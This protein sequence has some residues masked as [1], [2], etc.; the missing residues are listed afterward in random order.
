[1]YYRRI[2]LPAR[3][4]PRAVQPYTAFQRLHFA[5][6]PPIATRVVAA[7]VCDQS[8]SNCNRMGVRSL[9]LP[10]W[11]KTLLVAPDEYAVTKI[12]NSIVMVSRGGVERGRA[13]RACA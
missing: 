9:L 2:P 4:S 10:L 1:M 6:V 12:D 3:G 13:R 8:L 5:C 7:L 11:S